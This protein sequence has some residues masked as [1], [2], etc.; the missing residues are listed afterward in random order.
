MSCALVWCGDLFECVSRAQGSPVW[1]TDPALIAALTAP[2]EVLYAPIPLLAP[3]LVFLWGLVQAAGLWLLQ[4]TMQM[5]KMVAVALA[6]CAFFT[7][8]T[9]LVLEWSGVSAINWF[10]GGANY[11]WNSNDSIWGTVGTHLGSWWSNISTG[12]L[13]TYRQSV[14]W[15]YPLRLI[16]TTMATVFGVALAILTLRYILGLVG[17]NA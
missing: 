3:I 11:F 15:F 7:A 6:V 12:S 5:A 4:Q 10:G 1:V 13:A 8:L 9:I 16:I 14:E 2:R 17:R